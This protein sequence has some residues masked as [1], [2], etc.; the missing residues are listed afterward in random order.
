MCANNTRWEWS[1]LHPTV[2]QGRSI[3]RTCDEFRI[4]RTTTFNTTLTDEK[5]LKGLRWSPTLHMSIQGKN[6]AILEYCQLLKNQVRYDI[7]DLWTDGVIELDNEDIIPYKMFHY[8]NPH[9]IF[10]KN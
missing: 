1:L 5:G 2:H 3:Q 6:A 9:N 8:D 10:W 4:S 7:H